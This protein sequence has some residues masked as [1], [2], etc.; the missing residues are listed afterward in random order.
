M[1]LLSFMLAVCLLVQSDSGKILLRKRTKIPDEGKWELFGTYV[2]EQELLQESVMRILQS[3]AQ[4]YSPEVSIKFTG[5]YYD[6]VDRH[7]GARCVPLGFTA[8]I[9]EKEVLTHETLQ[10]FALNEVNSLDV[11]LDNAQIIAENT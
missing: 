7:P 9:A 3:K 2:Q 4:I 11:A 6:S 1:T 8:H 10:W 5:K